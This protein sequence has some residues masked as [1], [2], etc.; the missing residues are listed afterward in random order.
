MLNVKHTLQKVLFSINNPDICRLFYLIL[1][2]IVIGFIQ[3]QNIGF[4][5]NN[6]I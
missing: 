6:L 5:H 3:S 4:T 2:K 1:Y